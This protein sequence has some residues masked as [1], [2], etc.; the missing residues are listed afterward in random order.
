MSPDDTDRPGHDEGREVDA[1]ELTDLQD[2]LRVVAA[3]ALI[4]GILLDRLGPSVF[5]NYEQY[6]DWG[7][8]LVLAAVLVLLGER[9]AFALIDRFVRRP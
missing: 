3:F 4:A 2:K 7:L 5:D 8:G 1:A 6:S 9:G